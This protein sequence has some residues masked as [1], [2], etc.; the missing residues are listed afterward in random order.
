MANI[1]AA[2][3][4]VSGVFFAA[5]AGTTAP[6]D[7]TTTL[8]SAF[9]NGGY[10]S[11]DGIVQTIDRSTTKLRDMNGDDVFVVED[12]HEVSYRLTP[13]EINPM[14]FGQI[15]GASNVTDSSGEVTA[16]TINADPLTEQMYV[17]DMRLTG[18]EVLRVVIP[19]G[20]VTST[21]DITFRKGEPIMAE[22]TITAMPD[23]SGNKAYYYFA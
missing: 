9:K 19:R 16:V 10:V 2:R 17:F 21:G 23:A 6:T 8:A 1:K 13:M 22:L 4:K 14:T 18:A 12:G 7:A 5:P 20:I 11:E 3:P 15:F